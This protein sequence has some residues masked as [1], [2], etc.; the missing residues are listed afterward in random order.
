VNNIVDVTI[1]SPI[2]CKGPNDE[3]LV[4][5]VAAADALGRPT[6]ADEDKIIGMTDLLVILFFQ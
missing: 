5:A 2:A 4:G 3:A 1:K 6:K